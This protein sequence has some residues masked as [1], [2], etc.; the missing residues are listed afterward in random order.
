MNVASLQSKANYSSENVI[1]WGP[2]W[3]SVTESGTFFQIHKTLPE[4]WTYDTTN[5]ER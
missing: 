5:I 3:P 2:K 1:S 4:I